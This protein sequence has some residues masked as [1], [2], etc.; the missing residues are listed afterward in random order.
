MPPRS[1]RASDA[2]AYASFFRA[3]VSFG[4]PCDMV[5]FDYAL[6]NAP[7]LTADAL[8]GQLQV[9]RNGKPVAGDAAVREA[10][11]A[12]LDPALATL[13]GHALLVG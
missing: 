9:A 13:A 3:P 1:P 7:L 12:V 11:A 5:V 2:A 8:A 10:L 6:A 4:Q